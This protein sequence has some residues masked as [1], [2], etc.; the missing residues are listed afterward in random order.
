MARTRLT[1]VLTSLSLWV[2]V[3]LI[4]GLI[5]GAAAQVW[6][7][8]GGVGSVSLI[9]ALGTLWLNALKMTIIPLVFGLL[10]TGI[11]SIADAASTGRLALRAMA[12]FAGILIFATI[13]AIVGSETLHMLW[14]IDPE[15]GRALLA[16]APPEG[17]V[18]G[19]AQGGGLAAFLISL[20]PSNPVRAAAD[21]AILGIVVFAVAFGFA[22]TRL[23]ERLRLPMVAFFEA[24]S[25]TMIIIVHW[26]LLAAPVGVFALSLGV[27][28]RAGVGA[29]GTLGHYVAMVVLAQLGLI[30]IL[31]GV[32]VVFGRIGLARFAR[33]IVPAQVVAFSTQSSLASLP[34]MVEQ[35][36]TTLGVSQSTAGLVLPLAV[37]VFR[38]TSPVANL[39]VCIYVAHLHGIHLGPA[40]WFAGG[41]TALAVSVGSVGLPGQVSFF[42]SIAPICLA[43]GLPIEV[44]PLLLAV[45]VI[46]DIFRTI[47]NV[48]ADLAAARIV[49][50]PRAEVEPQPVPG[51]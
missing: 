42:V 45:E 9:E 12:V 46:P 2:L 51:I 22:A 14:P 25:E 5:A 1:A 3:A 8:P 29:A 19:S 41:L 28:L 16:G 37:A 17:V 40:A 23:P 7:I 49:E 10:V 15:G 39:A 24:V 38:A 6:G 32:A 18:R 36:R 11:A 31:Y 21:D 43:M 35:A 20:A 27:G 44:L 50:G 33:G 26:V 48:T 13:Y 4:A 34:A 47:G 30:I